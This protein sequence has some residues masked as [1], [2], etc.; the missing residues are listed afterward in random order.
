[1]ENRIKSA[2]QTPYTF[3][4]IKHLKFPEMLDPSLKFHNYKIL[5]SGITSECQMVWITFAN[6]FGP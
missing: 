4:Y 3:I 2:K 5:H 6:S 1:M